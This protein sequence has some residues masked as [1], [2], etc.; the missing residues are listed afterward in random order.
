MTDPSLQIGVGRNWHV[1]GIEI[2]G[3][4][5]RKTIFYERMIKRFVFS[6]FFR[7][8]NYF[9]RAAPHLG[10]ADI[11]TKYRHHRYWVSLKNTDT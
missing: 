3:G 5:A 8:R 11:D 4:S 2:T 7:A 6:F 10:W 9:L 1:P